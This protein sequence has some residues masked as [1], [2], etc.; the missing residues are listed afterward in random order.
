MDLHV[1]VCNL[2]LKSSKQKYW[3]FQVKTSTYTD[4][5][6]KLHAC[7]ALTVP[8]HVQ[9]VCKQC[10]DAIIQVRKLQE[11]VEQRVNDLRKKIQAVTTTTPLST[12]KRARSPTSGL[13]P[14]A[15][16]QHPAHAACKLFPRNPSTVT[17]STENEST[18]SNSTKEKCQYVPGQLFTATHTLPLILPKPTG[19]RVPLSS[20]ENETIPRHMVACSP[21][22]IPIRVKIVTDD[23]DCTAVKVCYSLLHYVTIRFY[24]ITTSG[25]H[26]RK[27]SF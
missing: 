8:S 1:H 21:S 17:V 16:R 27:M 19:V 6:G 5:G 24:V 11:N 10:R 3:L 9:T 15:K 7:T 4:L 14:A 13:S 18:N 22:R 12:S 25:D 26:I 2:C 23:I 20:Q